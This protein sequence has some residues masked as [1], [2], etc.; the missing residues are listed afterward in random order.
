[1]IT[2]TGLLVGAIAALVV[3]LSK[4]AL[5]GAG[6]IAT[7]LIATVVHGRALPGATLPIL[8]TADLFAVTW[9][10]RHARWDLLRTLVPGVALGFAA[11]AVFF[12]AVGSSSRTLDVVIGVTILVMVATQLVRTIR[13][14]D[15]VAPT[16]A[17]ATGYGA[18]GGFTTFVSNTAGPVMNTYLVRLGL[19]KN[20]MIGTS[21]WFYFAVNVAKVPVYL[22]L[23]E[24]STGGRFFSVTSIAYDALLVPAVIVGVCAGRAMFSRI[25]PAA[26]LWLVLVLSAAGAM[27]LLIR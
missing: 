6:L 26:F 15:A 16:L 27:K 9:Y 8:L 1:M 12:V 22:A 21:A 10:R 2:T 20:E 14:A 18:A 23:G 7:P 5:P 3:G 24:L 17:A 19:D 11:G 25:R 4:T 13:R